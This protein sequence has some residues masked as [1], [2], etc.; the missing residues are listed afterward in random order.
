MDGGVLVARRTGSFAT[1]KP[2]PT[3][4]HRGLTA[5]TL[6][7]APRRRKAVEAVRQADDACLEERRKMRA[8]ITRS[9]DAIISGQARGTVAGHQSRRSDVVA[10]R[11]CLSSG[12]G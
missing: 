11:P 4:A 7:E 3:I 9:A 1:V 5:L 12:P 10:L 6:H 8:T 2:A